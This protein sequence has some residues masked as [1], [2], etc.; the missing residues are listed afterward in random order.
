MRMKWIKFVIFCLV[1][2]ASAV[3][4][5]SLTEVVEFT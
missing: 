2:A 1:S 4:Q 3:N 5:L